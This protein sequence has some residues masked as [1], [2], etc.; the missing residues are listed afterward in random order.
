[1]NKTTTRLFALLA[2]SLTLAC[3]GAPTD[4]GLT[5]GGSASETEE[6]FEGVL[7]GY[8]ES[9]EDEGPTH[10]KRWNIEDAYAETVTTP[11]SHEDLT[12]NDRSPLIRVGGKVV[13]DSYTPPTEEMNGSA[14]T[15]S[16]CMPWLAARSI[17]T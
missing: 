7:T 5:D 14:S 3:G 15:P 11:S 2:L 4:E 13:S 1:M 9:E 6:S 10:W 16:P 17:P 8:G 12:S